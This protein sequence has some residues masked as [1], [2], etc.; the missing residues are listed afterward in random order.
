MDSVRRGID[1]D[2]YLSQQAKAILKRDYL[3]IDESIAVK[4]FKSEACADFQ[5]S[6]GTC[7]ICDDKASGIHYGVSTCEGCKVC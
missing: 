7:K 1:E 3:S 2:I 5:F 4:R 6:F